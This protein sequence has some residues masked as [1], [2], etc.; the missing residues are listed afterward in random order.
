MPVRNPPL[1]AGN[2]QSS[3][4]PLFGAPAGSSNRPADTQGHD[5]GL[6][7]G[8]PPL[9]VAG[10]F[11]QPGCF[12]ARAAAQE[13]TKKKQPGILATCERMNPETRQL[14]I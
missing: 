12:H 13:K 8:R 4:C 9:I 5:M 6:A 3:R 2:G 1:E 7:P 11:F 14:S 10:R